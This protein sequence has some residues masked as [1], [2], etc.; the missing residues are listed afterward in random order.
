MKDAIEMYESS[1][2]KLR[3]Q[4]LDALGGFIQKKKRQ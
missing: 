1:I 3:R 2:Q 4:R